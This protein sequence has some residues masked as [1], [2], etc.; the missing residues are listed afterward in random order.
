MSAVAKM[1]QA[2]F[3]PALSP[4]GGL[5]IEPASKLTPE[6]RAYI[7]AHKVL[8]LEELRA[9]LAPAAPEPQPVAFDLEAFE[10]RAAILEFEAGFSRDEAERR[11]L[12]LMSAENLAKLSIQAPSVES[13]IADPQPVVR[14]EP[15]CCGDCAHSV[16]PPDTCPVYGWRLCGLNV[17]AG[18]GF[19]QE[20]RR[21]DAW[22]I[23]R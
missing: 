19:G 8:L 20:A 13:A 3:I 16:L 9:E 6:Q 22:V 23:A 11:A 10:E 7:R 14:P 12:A 18:G 4:A 17:E 15:V 1:R 2:G 5:L 21:C